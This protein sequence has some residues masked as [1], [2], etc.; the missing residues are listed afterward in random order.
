MNTKTK[1]LLLSAAMVGLTTATLTACPSGDANAN[2]GQCHGI[3][4]CKATGDCGGKDHDC[5][6]RNECKGQGWKKMT[7][8][9]CESKSGKFVN[10]NGQAEEHSGGGH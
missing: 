5:A 9:A 4:E 7:K 10:P 1:K 8:E 2:E 3:N 6:G